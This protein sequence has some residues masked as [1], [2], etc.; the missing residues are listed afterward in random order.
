MIPINDSELIWLTYMVRDIYVVDSDTLAIKEDR[1][2]DLWDEAKD[3]WG[4]TL[5]KENGKIYMSDG[6]DHLLVIDQDTLEV[7]RTI[8]VTY[9]NGR[10]LFNINELEYVNG[11]IW[12]NVFLQ[13]YIVKI[14][15]QT[16]KIVKKIDL[17]SL[18]NAEMKKVKE[19]HQGYY[20]YMNNVLNGIAYDAAQDVF[21][22][23]GKRWDFMFKVKLHD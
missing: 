6:S 19:F 18:H 1:T 9:D 21:Y 13:K 2:F 12:A 20:D 4:M 8:N 14:D 15:I 5:D 23:T 16:G 7:E 17:T 22:L 11:Y 10:K 3:G